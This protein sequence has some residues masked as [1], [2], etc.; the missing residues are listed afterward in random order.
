MHTRAHARAHK[1]PSAKEHA[2]PPRKQRTE[3]EKENDAASDDR[4]ATA[5][6]RLAGRATAVPKQRPSTA[7]AA[8]SQRSAANEL[9]RLD[10]VQLQLRVED[11]EAKVEMLEELVQRLVM[12]QVTVVGGI[13]TK[14][15]QNQVCRGR[16]MK[17]TK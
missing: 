11:A 14:T 17:K 16:Q 3:D 7:V 2:A 4:W 6:N 8:K 9:A 5:A 12:N 1:Q 15:K 13:L 10:K